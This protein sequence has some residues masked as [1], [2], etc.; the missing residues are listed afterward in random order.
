MTCIIGGGVDL[1]AP[2]FIWHAGTPPSFTGSMQWYAQC[3]LCSDMQCALHGAHF[4]KHALCIFVLYYYAHCMTELIAQYF[5]FTDMHC[6]IVCR[7][8]FRVQ[9]TVLCAVCSL[10]CAVCSVQCMKGCWWD[11]MSRITKESSLGFLFSLTTIVLIIAIAIIT[12]LII[13]IAIITVIITDI[14]IVAFSAFC[15]IISS[16][17]SYTDWNWVPAHSQ[18][19]SPLIKINH[20]HHCNSRWIFTA[21][22]IMMMMII[23]HV[24]IFSDCE[25]LINQ[26][27]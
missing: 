7:V 15:I 6:T 21:I 9:F 4:I 17:R 10:Q 11:G 5:Q 22:I 12:V 25:Q 19:S 13:A 27:S 18:M 3:V 23:V 2:R 8:Q 24:S 20:D 14:I 26:D 1:C 16:K